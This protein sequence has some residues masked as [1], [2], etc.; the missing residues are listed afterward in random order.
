MDLRGNGGGHE[1]T[2]DPILRALKQQPCF[3][4]PKGLLVLT[5]AGT[6][7]SGHGTARTLQKAGGLLAGEEPGQPENAFGQLR[8]TRLPG[9][10]PAFACSTK[11][12]CYEPSD[13]SA[14]TRSLRVALPLEA[15]REDLLGLGDTV[16]DRVLALPF[17]ETG[18]P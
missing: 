7:S 14:W 16:L 1:P 15:S 8:F 6:F 11:R 10:H 13:P 2:F 12:F 17:P 3:K 4:R 9:L 5:D 18:H